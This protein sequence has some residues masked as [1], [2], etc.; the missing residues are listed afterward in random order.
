MD[1]GLDKISSIMVPDSEYGCGI[2][3]TSNIHQ[4]DVGIFLG[5]YVCMY[6]YIYIYMG[7]AVPLKS[8]QGL[9]GSTTR[10]PCFEA[11]KSKKEATCP[12]LAMPQ[13]SP[14]R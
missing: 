1:R 6:V 5:M 11:P 12:K 14:L 4:D 2:I 3:Y 8:F 7:P 9:A 10:V 13:R